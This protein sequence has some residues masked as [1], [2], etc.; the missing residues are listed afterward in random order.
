MVDIATQCSMAPI[1]AL[2]IAARQNIDSAYLEQILAKLKAIGLVK[3]FRGPGGGYKLSKPSKDILLSDIMVAAEE[4]FKMTRCNNSES[5]KCT[6]GESLCATHHLWLQLEQYIE[7][8][9][10]SVTLEDVCNTMPD[11][12]DATN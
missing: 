4:G 3:A 5:K 11:S 2:S 1:T 9:L 12:P 6:G 8:F 10:Q 7:H